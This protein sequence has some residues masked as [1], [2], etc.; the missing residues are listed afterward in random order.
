[1]SE[2]VKTLSGKGE[3]KAEI[4]LKGDEYDVVLFTG[5]RVD[6]IRNCAGKSIHYADDIAENW[7]NGLIKTDNPYSNAFID[8]SLEED[9]QR[10]S[11]KTRFDLEQ[12]IMHCWNIVDDINLIYTTHLDKR[13]LTPDELANIL[14][15][16]KELYQLKFETLFDTFEICCAK[17]D[18]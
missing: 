7:C 15:G 12:E 10:Q 9:R 16:L 17:R 14:I 4:W 2:I 3:R 1:M 11:S 8:L 6:E 13:E 18:I 5:S